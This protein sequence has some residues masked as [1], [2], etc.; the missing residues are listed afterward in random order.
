M[1]KWKYQITPKEIQY[2][3]NGKYRGAIITNEIP[4]KDK[5]RLGDFLIR[6]INSFIE[7]KA[8]E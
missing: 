2:F 8:D 3:C 5:R 7:D 4:K 1:K 6:I